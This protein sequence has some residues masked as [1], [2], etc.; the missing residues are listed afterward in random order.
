MSDRSD[1]KTA[2]GFDPVGSQDAVILILGTLP[3]Q[4]SLA[5]GQYY[6]QPR[7]AFWRIM[8]AIADAG[9]ELPYEERLRRL[10]A[11][12]IALWDVCASATRPG[13]LDARI[14]AASVRLNDF[15]RFL[16]EHPRIEVIGFN[17]RKSAALFK[18]VVPLLADPW[19]H[20]RLVTLPST[21]PAHA[22]MPLSG[23][24]DCWRKA[25]G[26]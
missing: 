22:A 19:S 18:P 25:L 14:R 7:N 10:A 6:A 2:S 1:D 23:K 13:S 17:G 5:A 11:H 12:R 16:A 3:G 20:I 21:S 15:P 24:V 8:G 9:P 26:A 4:A